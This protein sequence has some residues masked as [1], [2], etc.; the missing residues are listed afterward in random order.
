MMVSK[1]EAIKLIIERGT[2]VIGPVRMMSLLTEAGIRV[3]N[4]KIEADN[5]DESFEILTRTFAE[6]APTTRI[7]LL[8]LAKVYGFS[9]LEQEKKE[10][11]EKK[12]FWRLRFG[13]FFKR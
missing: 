6:I 10:K 5:I 8:S 11:K 7:T 12:S 13:R 1:A 2:G 9:V 3:I 4:D